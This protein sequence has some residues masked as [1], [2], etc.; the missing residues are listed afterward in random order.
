M[1]FP[2][3]KLLKASTPTNRGPRPVSFVAFGSLTEVKEIPG[4]IWS[5]AAGVPSNLHEA[6]LAVYNLDVKETLAAYAWFY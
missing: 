4:R 3:D 1:V 5:S 6:I 2:F